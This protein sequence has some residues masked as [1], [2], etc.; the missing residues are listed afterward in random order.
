MNDDTSDSRPL[1][2][3][4]LREADTLGQAWD[5]WLRDDIEPT[6]H[7]ASQ[8]LV[9]GIAA[10]VEELY[11]WDDAPAPDQG[12]RRSLKRDLLHMHDALRAT[13][14]ADTGELWLSSP[15]LGQPAAMSDALVPVPVEHPPRTKQWRL[16]RRW[17]PAMEFAAAAILILALFGITFGN[18]RIAEF[19]RDDDPEQF[20]A[21]GVATEYPIAPS[22]G[23]ERA[24]SNDA[25]QPQE[26][27]VAASGGGFGVADD[28]SIPMS[29]T[30]QQRW[31]NP[32][33]TTENTDA[34][35]NS[36]TVGDGLVAVVSVDPTSM[37]IVLS[38]YESE[39][40]DRRWRANVD[41]Y[42]D[43]NT[44]GQD[45][46]PV[47][48]NGKVYFVNRAGYFYMFDI[49]RYPNVDDPQALV[50]QKLDIDTV[51]TRMV[52][53][54]GSLFV[55]GG[56][57]SRIPSI[58][59]IG[60]MLFVTGTA[61][62]AVFEVDALSGTIVNTVPL[63]VDQPDVNRPSLYRY[64][65]PT[66][67]LSNVWNQPLAVPI[68]VNALDNGT[69]AV[70]FSSGLETTPGV[71]F[72]NPVDM[73]ELSTFESESIVV[74]AGVTRDTVVVTSLNESG[75]AELQSIQVS[76]T[77]VTL[78]TAWT[79][80]EVRNGA[81]PVIG[82]DVTLVVTDPGVIHLFDPSDGELVGETLVGMDHGLISALDTQNGSV[83]AAFEDGT[84]ARYDSE[85]ATQWSTPQPEATPQE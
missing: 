33:A 76:G 43:E 68:D 32:L 74:P 27:G 78:D 75:E 49:K 84:I 6:R 66:G 55:A 30:L 24:A 37:G 4:D 16:V 71:T 63:T 42:V 10:T 1:D 28:I 23:S 38:L 47:I 7:Q 40:G 85:T 82:G 52:L 31:V 77:P 41:D 46:A 83:Y 15:S 20:A 69:L 72:R 9:A 56:V 65:L 61:A 57:G 45:A 29:G 13:P 35:P 67:A 3:S 79:A 34:V 21:Q 64:D 8:T 12:F 70:T 62:D 50:S 44:I 19:F 14:A 17:W 39:T 2:L 81:N 80:D 18:A 60:Y 73:Q 53:S 26:A 59:G 51:A 48:A 5:S 25:P 22:T 58:A 36:M 54:G 11:D